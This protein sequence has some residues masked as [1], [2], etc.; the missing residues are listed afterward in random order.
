M[1]LPIII[2]FERHWDTIPKQA[3]KRMLPKLVQEGYNTLC[4][5]APKNL[6]TSDLISRINSAVEL[7]QSI[8]NQAESLLE[9]AHVKINGR[10]SDVSYQELT[11]LMQLYV[12]SNIEV[13]EKI[14]NLPASLLMKEILTNA[15]QLSM[16]I[17]GVDIDSEDYDPIISHDLS[18]RMNELDKS[19]NYRNTTILENLIKLSCRREGIIFM[20]GALHEPALI[21]LFK[22]RNMEDQIIYYF[23]HSSKLFDNSI[24][25][26][27]LL[28]NKGA[29]KEKFCLLS[30]ESDIEFFMNKIVVEIK[31]K[32]TKYT[33]EISDGCSHTQVLSKTYKANF[34]AFVRGGYYVDALLEVGGLTDI[35]NIDM[36]LRAH[37]I[38]SHYSFFQEKK[39]LVISDVNTKEVAENIRKLR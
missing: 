18:T 3:V 4:F 7:D 29:S 26:I 36:R 2:I 33:N 37:N 34:K 25:D 8:Y 20:C 9:Q 13:A 32:N 16:F 12:F 22:Q 23:P 38:Q 1:P 35:N 6:Q 21:S 31:A 10:I 15:T 30:N 39:Y 14:K 27:N 11:K 28:K 17:E 19:E 24:D 5:E